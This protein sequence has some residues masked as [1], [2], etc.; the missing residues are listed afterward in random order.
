M[1]EKEK[2]EN[3]AEEKNT[4][5]R[6]KWLINIGKAAALAG[7][8]GT[9]GSVEAETVS[10]E[11]PAASEL[12]PGLYMPSV[13]HLT[14]V[15]S[16][17]SR[18]HPIPPG[19]PTDFVRPRSGPYEPQF[20]SDDEYQMIH[21]LTELM[22]GES[23][24]PAGSQGGIVDEVAEWV[25]LRTFSFA[26][27]RA[28]ARKFTHAQHVLAVAYDGA[29]LLHE[30][31]TTDPQKTYHDGLAWIA[32]EAGRVGQR[33]F[34]DLSEDQQIAILDQISDAREDLSVENNSTRFFKQLKHDVI[35][36]FYTSQVGLKELDY[37]GNSFHAE[38]P[39][40]SSSVH[41]HKEAER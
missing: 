40:C 2:A 3:A 12:P 29:P 8:A 30:L 35:D 14:H 13:D 33:N 36:G 19:C 16:H 6:R 1:N 31:E 38:S 34:L 10:A 20:F 15:L 28:A 23:S 25:D 7:I 39:G 37:Q 9:A 27:A 11:S 22:L 24:A 21:R 4:L 18:F 17:D 26:G 5:T 32:E 41:L